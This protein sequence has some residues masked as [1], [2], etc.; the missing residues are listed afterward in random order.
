MKSTTFEE[1][2]NRLN[3]L[4]KIEDNIIE[5][6]QCCQGKAYTQAIAEATLRRK[7]IRLALDEI[8]LL[9]KE[10]PDD[11]IDHENTILEFPL[12]V[13]EKSIGHFTLTNKDTTIEDLISAGLGVRVGM[14]GNLNE[15]RKAE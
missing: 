10:L 8:K 3:A 15:D 5:D 11:D 4:V 6:N 14:R 12:F 13:G 1:I 9:F 7:G 2:E